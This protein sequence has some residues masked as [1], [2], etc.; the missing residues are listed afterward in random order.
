MVQPP[1]AFLL[2]VRIEDVL[3]WGESRYVDVTDPAYGLREVAQ[4]VAL[5]EARELRNIV[6]ANIEQTRDSSVLQDRKERFR[7]LLRET[8]G[9]ELHPVATLVSTG[10]PPVASSRV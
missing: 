5:C 6:K 7:G 2:L 8:Y 4:V 1:I 10:S 3:C 9:E